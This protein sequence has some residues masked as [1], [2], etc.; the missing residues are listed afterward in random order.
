MS[1]LSLVNTLP[2]PLD[3]EL[4]YRPAKALPYINSSGES[5]E[6]TLLATG[7]PAEKPRIMFWLQQRC[8]SSNFIITKHAARAFGTFDPRLVKGI[9]PLKGLKLVSS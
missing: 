7:W 1:V 5:T 6:A 4:E 9:A 2:Q 3:E 8:D